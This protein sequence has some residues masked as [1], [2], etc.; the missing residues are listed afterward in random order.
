M[1]FGRF[2]GQFVQGAVLEAVKEVE[3]AY[4]TWSNDSGFQNEFR[5][6]L[7]EYANRPS[8]LYY[9]K[10][11]TERLGGAKIY[12]KREDLNHTGAHKINNALGQVLLA[13]KMGKSKLIA[14]TG[15]GQHGVATATVAALF[16]L[17]CDIYMGEV[18]ALR[19]KMNVYRMELLG[20]R[21]VIV[22]EGLKTLKEAVDKAL[23]A[24]SRELDRAFYLIG[25]AVGPHPYPTM[26]RDFQKV[27]GE[28]IKAQ[29]MEKEK[30]LPDYIVACIGGGSNA[31]GAFYDFLGDRN[32]KLVGVEAA[33]KGLETK[34]H[35]ATISKGKEAHIHG[36]N[37]ICLVESNGDISPVYS[38]SAGLDYPGVGPEHAYLH[39]I[40][41]VHYASATDKEAVEAFKLLAQCKGI[42]PAIESA[43]ALA[44]AF[45]L[46]EKLDKNKIIVVNL[47][48]RGDKDVEQI[49]NYE[50]G[51]HNL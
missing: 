29:L 12:L 35:S 38:I 8:L 20:A 42:I 46:A 9:A 7:K 49:S 23:E 22:K 5:Y 36:M 10:N 14:E 1:E 31:I 51:V 3:R 32:V 44:E 37:T 2:G 33:G 24:W 41:R 17:E 4:A 6:Y 25:S 40:G 11:I 13:R 48:G 47:S 18:D 45:K 27:I 19:Q 50:K 30:Q 26:V 34:E 28:E 43:H 21:V 39:E 15:A 16:G